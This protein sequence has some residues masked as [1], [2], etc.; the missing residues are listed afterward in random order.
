MGDA[1]HD[2][3]GKRRA[4][5][6]QEKGTAAVGDGVNSRPSGGRK[7]CCAAYNWDAALDIYAA[8]FSVEPKLNLIMVDVC[9][10]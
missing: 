3:L 9:V 7:L 10:F 1:Y 6:P 4:T 5:V 8:L 2:V